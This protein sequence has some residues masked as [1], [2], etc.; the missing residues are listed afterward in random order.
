M[1]FEE[2]HIDFS[3]HVILRFSG[4][5]IEQSTKNV[6]THLPTLPILLAD[7]YPCPVRNPV[8]SH[9]L[10]GVSR[11]VGREKTLVKDIIHQVCGMVRDARNFL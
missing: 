4:F 11:T 1:N 5:F 9:T 7:P 2:N 6:L 10:T 8:K 3:H